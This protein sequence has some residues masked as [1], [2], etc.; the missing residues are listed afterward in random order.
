MS[1][2]VGTSHKGCRSMTTSK[3]GCKVVDNDDGIG[4]AESSEIGLSSSISL[5][6]LIS[7]ASL[8]VLLAL[9][10]HSDMVRAVME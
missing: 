4:L 9:T 8:S 3:I 10:A 5:N 2:T 1:R 6:Q 7:D